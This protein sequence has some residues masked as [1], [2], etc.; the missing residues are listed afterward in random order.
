MREIT[1]GHIV[2]RFD[3]E[4]SHLRSLVL[5]M[6]GLVLDQIHL[7]V[8]AFNEGDI[9]LALYVIERDHVVNGF[10]MQ[11]DEEEYSLLARRVP[12]ALDLRIIVFVA[13]TITDLERIGDE[14][15]KIARVTKRFFISGRC[16]KVD[17]TLIDDVN[18]MARFATTQL[19]S[20]LTAFDQANIDV[21]VGVAQADETLDQ[22]CRS[23]IHNLAV[24]LKNT[25]GSTQVEQALDTVFIIKVLERIGDHA[26]N[27]AEYVIY[28]LKGK[29]VCHVSPATLATEAYAN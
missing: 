24:A 12:V 6:G 1:G 7:A 4:L 13:K 2:K 8:K 20:C 27:I 23:P 28:M 18:T 25:T 17:K 15:D 26:K 3:G 5:E 22:M 16:S 19:R 21:A 10:N 14:A 9:K 29:D 11:A